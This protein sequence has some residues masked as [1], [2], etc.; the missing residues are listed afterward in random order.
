MRPEQPQA[1]L[2]VSPAPD[3]VAQTA[4]RSR[5]GFD[6]AAAAIL[7]TMLTLIVMLTVLLVAESLRTAPD[8][9]S[10]A[11]GSVSPHRA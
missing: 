8:P 7:G 10:T 3:A 1:A 6:R 4:T 5:D 11:Q 9:A 2:P